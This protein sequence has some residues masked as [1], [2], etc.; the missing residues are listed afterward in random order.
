MKV[1]RNGKNVTNYRWAVFLLYTDK[2]QCFS[3]AYEDAI[4][5]L[6]GCRG[7]RITHEHQFNLSVG[8]VNFQ[9]NLRSQNYLV[10]QLIITVYLEQRVIQFH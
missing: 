10:G 6:R 5:S 2:W 4:G 3:G 1:N 8:S 9:L 7:S